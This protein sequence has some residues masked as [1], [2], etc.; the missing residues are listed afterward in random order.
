MDLSPDEFLKGDE[1]DPDM[2]DMNMRQH[3]FEKW[4]DNRRDTPTFHGDDGKIWSL[5]D[6]ARAAKRPYF[7]GAGNK[8]TKAGDRIASKKRAGSKVSS[9]SQV[10]NFVE[11]LKH[12]SV[13][14]GIMVG[15]KKVGSQWEIATPELKYNTL[16]M[17]AKEIL[18]VQHCLDNPI[19]EFSEKSLA[20]EYEGEI[21]EDVY[22]PH[23]LEGEKIDVPYKTTYADWEDAKLYFMIALDVGWRASEG[24]TATANYLSAT[25]DPAFSTGIYIEGKD[26]N[27]PEGI[28]F[29]KF[30]TRKTW[31]MKDKKG[32]LRT[33]HS[34]MILTSETREL[35]QA[36]VNKVEAGM[37]QIGKIPDDELFKEYGIERWTI[38]AEGVKIKNNH[39]ALIGDDGKYI[40]SATMKFPTKHKL[41]PRQVFEIKKTRKPLPQLKATENQKKLHAI[42][43]KCF[44]E[45][46][47]NLDEVIDGIV[48]GQYWLQDTLHSLRHVFAQKW[49]LQ[50]GWNFT[51]VA[52]KGH[53]ASTKILED[54]Y[55]GQGNKTYMM[56]S[57][58]FAQMKLEDVE[59]E[60]QQKMAESLLKFAQSTK[61]G[62][63]DGASGNK[64]T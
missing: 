24:L 30:L 27:L 63:T 52:R 33:Y 34:E 9:G 35:V 51:H 8:F 45:S 18:A 25:D 13:T 3:A 29:I 61:E 56:D 49:L 2:Q 54:A 39:H 44:V 41:S 20:L 26:P 53:W 40:D 14:A 36:K 1:T 21:V 5:N 59:K 37:K 11:A 16:K 31:K 50:S 38:N 10:R 12:F 43:R 62:Q 32:K 60:E 7:A 23:K 55:G 46:G 42:M 58:H 4:L 17:T 15:G 22:V 48:I 28:M 64:I 6:W 19:L 57:I 47:V